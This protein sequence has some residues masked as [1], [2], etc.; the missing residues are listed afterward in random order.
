MASRDPTH[1]GKLRQAFRGEA[2]RRV[3]TLLTATRDMLVEQSAFGSLTHPMMMV[4]FF[5]RSLP[6]EI[7]T[8]LDVFTGWF[9]NAI[10][11]SVVQEGQWLRQHALRAYQHGLL[12]GER[13][14]G[15]PLISQPDEVYFRFYTNE[16]EGVADATVQQVARAVST[17]LLNR[18]GGLTIYRRVV[19]VTMKVTEPRLNALGHQI[20]VQQHNL[21]LLAQFRSVGVTQV[22]IVPEMQPRKVKLPKR[23]AV[24]DQEIVNVLTAGDDAVCAECEDIAANGPYDIDEAETL[25]PAHPSCR[26]EFAPA[27]DLRT[28]IETIRSAAKLLT[29]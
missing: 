16:L 2:Q 4:A 28:A 22:G 9:A 6:T 25:I 10:Y 21:G 29:E 7:S 26:C 23:D 17:G 5:R 12:A 14:T 19:A 20:V 3:R 27:G 8:K 13:I 11:Q 15:K 1:T 24:T 18:E